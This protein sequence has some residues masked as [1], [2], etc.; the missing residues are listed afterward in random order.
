MSLFDFLTEDKKPGTFASLRLEERCSKKLHKWMENQQIEQLVDTV[1]YHCTIVF[2]SKP[3]EGI[4]KLDY[5]SSTSI[6]GWKVLGGPKMLV[7]LLDD[8]KLKLLFDKT[9]EMGAV[10]K[11][12]SFL[13][14]ISVALNYKGELPTKLPNIEIQFEEFR[15]EGLNRDFDYKDSA[16]S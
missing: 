9:I 4:E 3:V 10:T 15:V 14:H 13:P 6:V 5:P 11:Y 7:A 8:S 16:D 2:S 12:P 1:D